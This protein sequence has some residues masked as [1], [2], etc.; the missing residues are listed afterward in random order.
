MY[1]RSLARLEKTP[2]FGMTP[3]NS[4][5]GSKA[6]RTRFDQR[7]FCIASRFP[8]PTRIVEIASPR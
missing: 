8:E 2:G 4:S 1:A 3:G 7:C 6:H 5:I